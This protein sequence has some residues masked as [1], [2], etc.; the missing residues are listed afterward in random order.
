VAAASTDSSSARTVS[1]RHPT[2]TRARG[3]AVSLGVAAFFDMSLA[4]K[5]TFAGVSLLRFATTTV[6]FLRIRQGRVSSTASG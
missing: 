6:A 2:S 3:P 1:L 5:A 4:A